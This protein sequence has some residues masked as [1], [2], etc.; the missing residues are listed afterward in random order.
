LGFSEVEEAFMHFQFEVAPPTPA[1]VLIPSA[2]PPSEG[3]IEVLR[4][5]LEVQTEQ[6]N[7]MKLAQASGDNLSRWRGLLGRWNNEFPSLGDQCREILPHLER[8]YLRLIDD[9][10][11]Q[12]TH[13][14][15]DGIDNDFSLNEFLDRYGMRLSQ[16]GTILS[17]VG[18]LA[19]AGTPRET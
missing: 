13:E 19:D 10:A 5:L 9:L 8:G 15:N 14:E 2:R 16:L 11:R 18:T 17:L 6:L 1:T 12:L 7:L 3:T 4:K